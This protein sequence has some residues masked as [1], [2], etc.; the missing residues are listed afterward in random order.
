MMSRSATTTFA[1]R[2]ST[3]RRLRRRA[4]AANAATRTY[5]RTN[6]CTSFLESDAATG[7]TSCPIC[8]Y[9]LRAN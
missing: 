1:G 4:S 3:M 9:V 7:V 2:S 8:G 5:C 6:G